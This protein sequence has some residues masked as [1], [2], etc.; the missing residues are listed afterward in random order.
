MTKSALKNFNEKN[1]TQKDVCIIGAI[2]PSSGS[3]NTGF[4]FLSLTYRLGEHI[5]NKLKLRGPKV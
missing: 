1:L 2:F 5:S 3:A 4:N